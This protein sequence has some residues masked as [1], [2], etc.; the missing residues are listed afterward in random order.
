MRILGL[1][2]RW[3][4]FIPVGYIG[5]LILRLL[6]VLAVAYALNTKMGDLN[7]LVVLL[8]L[9][10]GSVVL[11][12]VGAILSGIGYATFFACAI[13]APNNKAGSA[14]FGTV[15]VITQLPY[16]IGIFRSQGF[17]MGLAELAVSVAALIGCCIA[18]YADTLDVAPKKSVASP[19]DETTSDDDPPTAMQ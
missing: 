9:L 16:T 18:F 10:V 2:L 6:I 14:I 5:F 4:V 1:I 11:S 3:L 12:V 13:V 15:L 17:W 8:F 19:V 7:L